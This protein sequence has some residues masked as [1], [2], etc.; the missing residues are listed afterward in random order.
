MSTRETA[1]VNTS[2]A[3]SNQGT[4]SGGPRVKELFELPESIHRIAFVEKLSEAI[5]RPETT[6]ANY[7]L[8]PPLV[9]AFD[10]A[11]RLVG[12]S[13]RD[14]RSQAAYLHGSFG[15]GKSHFMA[16]VSLALGGSEPVWRLPE[17]HPL[18]AK[19]PFVGQ[20]RLLLLHFHLVGHESLEQ[21]IFLR[22]LEHVR[23]EHAGA[24][25]PGLFADEELFSDARRMREELGDE[26]FFAPMNAGLATDDAWGEYGQAPV[27]DRDRFD[28][29]AGSTD[30]AGREALFSALVTTRFR[31]YAQEHRKLIDLD[32]G[33]AVIGRHAKGLGYQG[34]VLF[35]DELVLWL[36]SRAAEVTWFH[37]EVQKMV[38][39]VEAQEASRALPFVS[40]IAR[41]RDL[42][43][44]VGE[45]YAGSEN[46]RVRDS[47]KWSEGRYEKVTL[48]DRN[49][50]AIAEKRV[51]RARSEEAR[52]TLDQA[53]QQMK[54]SVGEATWQ[55][56][57]GKLDAQ[58]F[59]RLYPFSPALV[60]ALV[61]LSN[62][63][64][65]ERTA[66]KLLTELLVEHVEDLELG[67]VVCVGDL[68]DVLAGGEDTAS[69]PMKARFESAKQLYAYQFLPLLQ[70]RHGTTTA[71]R[72]QRLRP[73]HP[74]RLGCSN[75]PN[76][77]CRTDNRLIKT[78]LVAA[79]VP[80]VPSLKDLTASKLVQLNHGSL[81]VPIPG[82]E[83]NAV[84][85]KLQ[86][87]ASAIGQL[88]LGRNADPSVRLQ[89]EGVD[90]EPIL[91][92]ARREDTPGVRQRVLRD[93]LFHEMGVGEVKDWAVDWELEWRG[94]RRRGQVAFANVRKLSPEALR[95]P[96]AHDWRL[97]VDYPFDEP[98]FG[99]ADD[100]AHLQAFCEQG[101][102]SY[103]LVWVPSFFSHAM[104]QMLGDLVVL[105]HILATPAQTR[106]YVS[107]L[108]VEQQGRAVNDLT[109]LRTQK[110]SRLRQALAQAYGLAKVREGDLDSARLVERHLHVLKPGVQLR[111]QLAPNLADAI[112]AYVKALLE[113]RYPRHPQ[114]TKPLT[115]NRVEELV[116]VFGQLV[117]AEDKRIPVAERALAEEVRGTLGELGLVR[118]TEGAAH[119]LEDR[120]LQEL[121]NRRQQQASERPLVGE[122]RRWIDEGGRMGLQ[123][124]ALDLVV[125]C[126]ARYAARTLVLG[127]QPFEVKPRQRIPDEVVL[128]K[129]DLPTHAAW[130]AALGLVWEA[131][132]LPH[133][134]KA[135]HG[136]NLKRLEAELGGKLKELGPAC[137]RL[138]GLLRG[139]LEALGL[140]TS[141]DRLRTA[142]SAEALC[143][144]LAGQ[145]SKT[146]V[147]LL[148]AFR[149]ETSARALGASIRTAKETL[150]VLE[151]ALVFGAIGQLAARRTER[152]GAAELLEE[153]AGALR[154]DEL[155]VRLAPRLRALAEKG[156]R[157]LSPVELVGRVVYERAL[158]GEGRAAAIELLRAVLA[159]AE[160]ALA[161]GGES[162]TVTGELRIVSREPGA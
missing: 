107:H 49:L 94:T 33:L 40:F 126:Y 117:D 108:S 119:L 157:L 52:R 63:L 25:L 115:A 42:A 32:S 53:F 150:A 89:L 4:R 158:K 79:L 22:Y 130:N 131:F 43:E 30:P 5:L 24:P 19:H 153:V 128:E 155:N 20:A 71:E 81:R 138:P 47:L 86:D 8:T 95:C 54:S 18:R 7:V 38:K 29:A 59:R 17:L 145:R 13:L 28:A 120:R 106:K 118:V 143:A 116:R 64:Q 62:S 134:G 12:A 156:L 76:R 87:W 50:P 60:E 137:A 35:L 88:H 135:L 133:A 139:R 56:L 3:T 66:I 85:K 104:N 37:N 154:Q 142:S 83:A 159:E 68:Y 78:L 101:A 132:S 99:P 9:E 121:E 27:W 46:A 124:E 48:E 39:L 160:G 10:R 16:L 69:G 74:A 73:D 57:L 6:A 162:V 84:A 51:L 144:A 113:A 44:M 36:A 97:I 55:T 2:Q 105:E 67:Q 23:R 103:T 92:Q 110:Q 136:D 41:Q 112:D 34:V 26:A 61:A 98:G 123:T 91:E 122:V 80:E 140:E 31:S 1:P 72:C 151:D 82:D 114:L 15:S 96:E 141:V 147:E 75:C 148:A 77:A 21:A 109:N 146:Q 100:E 14:G 65:R 58:D 102:G 90:L 45:D 161:A 152:A 11:L 149:P 125:R 111:A 70:D 93:L 127:D 129:P